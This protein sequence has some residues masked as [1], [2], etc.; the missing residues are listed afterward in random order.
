MIKKLIVVFVAFIAVNTF[1]QQGT[2]SPYSFYGIGTLNFRG[3]VENRSM[4][5]LSIYNDSIQVNLRNPA[6]HTG[7]NLKSFNDESRPVRFAVGGNFNNTSL[8]TQNASS[9]VASATFEYLA[10]NLPAGKFG[11]TLGMLPFTSVG[12][13]L[14]DLNENGLLTN[15]YEGE[16]GLNKVFLGVGYS[17]TRNLRVG[18]NLD[19]NFGSIENSSIA[20]VRDIEGNLLQFQT[21]QS[22]ASNLTGLNYTLG[23]SYT[24]KFKEKYDLM[25]SATFKP[26]SN[27]V[28]QNE[29]VFSTIIINPSTGADS[30]V[31]R[32]DVDLEGSGLA[33]TELTLP[34]R[35]ALGAGIGETHKWFLGA[36]YSFQQTS[37]FANP[38]VNIDNTTFEDSYGIAVGGFYI[39]DYNAFKGYLKRVVYRT[40]F[41]YETTGLNINNQSIDEFGITFGVG[42]PIGRYGTNLNIGFEYGQRGTTSQNL[43]KEGFF[44][45]HIS[46]TLNDRWFEK[47]KYN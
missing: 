1:A 39:P 15:R 32:I 22:N 41:R 30:E 47:R 36:E 2:V 8:R 43:I 23:T 20:F 37:K 3:T 27:I 34:S 5:G 25:V 33:E 26:Q 24:T 10:L 12:Y 13:N 18:V 17:V 29:R 38:I 16:G 35:F 46:L 31:D 21:K 45:T 14:Q 28:S 19:Y 7:N 4:G 6:F 44:N 11:F 42:L 40:G 9:S